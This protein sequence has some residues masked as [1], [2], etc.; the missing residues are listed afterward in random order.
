MDTLVIAKDF[1]KAHRNVL[2]KV[3]QVLL[4]EPKYKKHMILSKYK[5]KRGR[6]YDKFVFSEI[7]MDK[8][9]SIYETCKNNYSIEAGYIDF[10]E[11]MIDSEPIREF[12]IE[13]TPYKIDLA[14]P[15]LSI[16]IEIDGKYHETKKQKDKDLEREKS[17]IGNL[18][19][20]TKEDAIEGGNNCRDDFD[21]NRWFKF[22]RIKQDFLPEGLLEIFQ[23]IEEIGVSYASEHLKKSNIVYNYSDKEHVPDFKNLLK[24]R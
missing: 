11:R 1:E 5:N 4:H 9:L 24:L 7:G 2:S 15:A 14:F 17:I 23:A 3:R 8:I 6:F 20:L 13:G 22:I 10:I 19:K 18:F 16:Y 21:F 12:R